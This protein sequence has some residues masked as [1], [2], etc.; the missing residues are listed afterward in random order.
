VTGGTLL[1]QEGAA[2]GT[3]AYMSPEQ[4]RG[5]EVDQRTDIWS[6]GVV[7][8]EMLT[9]ELP[10][11][12]EHEQAV[13]YSIRKDKPRPITEVNADIPPARSIQ[14]AT[15]PGSEDGFT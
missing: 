10:F 9:G 13:V 12:G 3:I 11:K 7:L 15:M 14:K 8:Y 1:T 4:A 2:M 5:K 6:F